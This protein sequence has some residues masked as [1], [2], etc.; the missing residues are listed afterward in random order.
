M[1]RPKFMNHLGIMG[2]SIHT[3]NLATGL[4]IVANVGTEVQIKY[5]ESHENKIVRRTCHS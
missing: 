1:F 3:I 4:H 2:C 5:V